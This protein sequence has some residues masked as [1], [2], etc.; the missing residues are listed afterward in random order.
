MNRVKRS[1]FIDPIDEAVSNNL[2]SSQLN[3]EHQGTLEDNDI[4]ILESLIFPDTERSYKALDLK[5]S[6][7]VHEALRESFK[8]ECK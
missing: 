4:A 7:K 6:N 5:T 2:S 3:S 8:E 1:L